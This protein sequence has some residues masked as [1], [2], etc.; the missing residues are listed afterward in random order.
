MRLLF[1]KIEQEN[2]RRYSNALPISKITTRLENISFFI[3]KSTIYKYEFWRWE[4]LRDKVKGK[5]RKG[6]YKKTMRRSMCCCHPWMANINKTFQLHFVVLLLC[7]S[8]P[9]IAWYKSYIIKRSNDYSVWSWHSE[10][11]SNYKIMCYL[12]IHDEWQQKNFL[13]LLQFS[14]SP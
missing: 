7:Q 2:T 4:L 1:S 12:I 13:I 10:L 5:R 8:L 11:T 6:L 3:N 14:L 9:L